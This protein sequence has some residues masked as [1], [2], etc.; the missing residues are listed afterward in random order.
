ME[1][2]L[3]PDALEYHRVPTPGKISVTPTKSLV[4]LSTAKSAHMLT[5]TA[6]VRGILNMT[7]LAVVDAAQAGA[8]ERVRIAAE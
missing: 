7:A 1:E 4:L 2:Q 3:R 6:T 5:Q 8:R